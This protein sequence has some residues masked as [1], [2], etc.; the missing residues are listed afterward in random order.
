MSYPEDITDSIGHVLSYYRG[1]TDSARAR[2]HL[3]FM[4]L[5]NPEL[6]ASRFLLIYS[7]RHSR[8]RIIAVLHLAW[9]SRSSQPASDL[10][11][12]SVKPMPCC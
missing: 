4:G 2:D 10:L 3:T 8:C 6:K 12:S 1:M 5:A 7:Y 11:E 9:V